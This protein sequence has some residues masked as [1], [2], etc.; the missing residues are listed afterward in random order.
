MKLYLVLLIIGLVAFSSIQ[1]VK[2]TTCLDCPR[3]QPEG[4]T[5][6]P[7]EILCAPFVGCCCIPKPKQR[8]LR[9]E[10]QKFLVLL[11]LTRSNSEGSFDSESSNVELL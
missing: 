10:K 8:L 11:N 9:V 7:A 2:S 5:C 1:E 4:C 3:F 6:S